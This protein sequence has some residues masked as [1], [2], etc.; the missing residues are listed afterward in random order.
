LVFTLVELLVVNRNHRVLI[1]ILLPALNKGA[2]SGEGG[3]HAP[4]NIPQLG[5]RL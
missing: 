4:S 3:Q 5:T 1:G 2:Q